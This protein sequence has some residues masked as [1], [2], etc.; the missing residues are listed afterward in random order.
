MRGAFL[1][2]ILISLLIGCFIVIKN[3]NSTSEEGMTKV[4]TIQKA[5]EIQNIAEEALKQK[6]NDA[7]K[8]IDDI[9][10]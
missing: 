5:K 4:E 9:S 2:V 3:M 6:V 7:K 10:K 1:I 8:A